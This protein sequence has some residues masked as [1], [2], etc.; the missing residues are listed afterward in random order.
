MSIFFVNNIAWL[1][2]CNNAWKFNP[3]QPLTLSTN[4]K[5]TL[6]SKNWKLVNRH[7]TLQTQNNFKL[8]ELQNFKCYARK[9]I[10]CVS[11]NFLLTKITTQKA[12]NICLFL[13]L[14]FKR[15]KRHFRR[16]LK[17]QWWVV[18]KLFCIWIIIS[19]IFY[20]YHCN[21]WMRNDFE[22]TVTF[23]KWGN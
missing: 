16:F 9:W 19:V 22:V 20:W 11:F 8:P 14:H 13:R 10:S 21:V 12:W 23:I 7:N 4:Y 2:F 5:S 1:C 18:T 17:L 6:I 3:L 15:I